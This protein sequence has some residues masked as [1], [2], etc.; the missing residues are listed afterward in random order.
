MNLPGVGE[1]GISDTGTMQSTWENLYALLEFKEY[2]GQA[3][4]RQG[5]QK[6]HR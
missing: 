4:I 2:D 3:L 5:N 1:P 6:A